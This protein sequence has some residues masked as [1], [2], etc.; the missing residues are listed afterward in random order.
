MNKAI[1]IGDVQ[2]AVKNDNIVE[3]GEMIDSLNEMGIDINSLMDPIDGESLLHIAAKNGHASMVKLLIEKG[4]DPDRRNTGKELGLVGNSPLERVITYS[5][6]AYVSSYHEVLTALLDAGAGEP[7]HSGRTAL[8]FAIAS[9]NDDA[10][11]AIL[12][13]ERGR[14]LIAWHNE[15]CTRTTPLLHL[16]M[17]VTNSI[18]SLSAYNRVSMLQ[19]LLDAGADP[20]EK[21]NR[22]FTFLEDAENKGEDV[23]KL[24]DEL[25]FPEEESDTLLPEP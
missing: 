6:G 10:V 9:R 20:R 17:Y 19:K 3:A 13:H 2:K 18:N 23:S 21:D 16:A 24:R 11:A 12:K 8:S 14:E 15:N 22:G 5:K 4:H 1:N 25:R 7:D